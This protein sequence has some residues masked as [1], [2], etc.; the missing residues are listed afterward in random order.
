MLADALLWLEKTGIACTITSQLT[1]P[2]SP[3]YWRNIG[4]NNVF[5]Q[6]YN[7]GYETHVEEMVRAN[8]DGQSGQLDTVSLWNG[9]SHVVPVPS[10]ETMPGTKP[11]TSMKC[12]VID[13]LSWQSARACRYN[14]ECLGFPRNAGSERTCRGASGD[15]L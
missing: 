11:L 10:M 5:V 4:Y 6:V 8:E 2:G 13:K 9:L 12:T 14:L 3:K 7:W 15:A 1:L